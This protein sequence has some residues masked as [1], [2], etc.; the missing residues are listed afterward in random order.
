M[1]HV[2]LRLVKRC[3]EKCR[4]IAGET[5]QT[6]CCRAAYH[7]MALTMAQPSFVRTRNGGIAPFFSHVHEPLP[8]RSLAPFSPSPR[9]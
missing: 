1:C 8:H 5:R 2:S 6:C 7:Y 9:H 3:V 4:P